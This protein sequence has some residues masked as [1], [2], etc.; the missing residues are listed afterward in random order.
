[1]REFL[2]IAERPVDNS[3]GGRSWLPL[4]FGGDQ[5]P[6]VASLQ[7]LRC[8]LRQGSADHDDTAPWMPAP[9]DPGGPFMAGQRCVRYPICVNTEITIAAIRT[10]PNPIRRCAT[11][12]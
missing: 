6:V 7:V 2:L 9:S 4:R 1:M 12:R 11:P 8:W 10:I 5:R 3:S